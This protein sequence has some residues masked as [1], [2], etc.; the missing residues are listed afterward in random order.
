MT[1]ALGILARDGAVLAADTEEISGYTGGIKN[2]VQKIMRSMRG[3]VAGE[4]QLAQAISGAGSGTYLDAVMPKVLT[5][6]AISPYDPDEAERAIESCIAKF[7]KRHVLPF[8]GLPDER[9][10]FALILAAQCGNCYRLWATDKTTVRRCLPYASVGVGS[11]YA[12]MLLS[13]LCTIDM[14]LELAQIVAGYVVFKVKHTI[15]GCGKET[16]IVRLQGGGAQSVS[17]MDV[18]YLEGVYKE[19]A[20]LELRALSYAMGYPTGDAQGDQEKILA[21]LLS[22]R[23]KFAPFHERSS[24]SSTSDQT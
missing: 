1:I 4:F 13:Q 5:A 16:D 14:D 6:A 19:W 8:S 11:M 20:F 24:K 9:P 21:R 22:V 3:A 10:D 17:P 7:Y 15:E 2:S 23:T 12:N 18:E